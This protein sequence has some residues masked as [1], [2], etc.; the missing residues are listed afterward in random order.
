[1]IR[2]IE[3][4][5]WRPENG[6]TVTVESIA[7]TAASLVATP[8]GDR[9][10][11][12]HLADC[13]SEDGSSFSLA[14]RSILEAAIADTI[15]CDGRM[16]VTF[17]MPPKSQSWWHYLSVK[18]GA[19]AAYV[20]ID[21]TTTLQSILCSTGRYQA[22]QRHQPVVQYQSRPAPQKRPIQGLTADCKVVTNAFSADKWW[23][24]LGAGYESQL[25]LIDCY[26][27]PLITDRSTPPTQRA[28]EAYRH[29]SHLID[30]APSLAVTFPE[31]VEPHGW[32]SSLAN[33]ESHA[34]W[35]WLN[36]RDTLNDVL[37]SRSLATKSKPG[38][39]NSY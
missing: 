34:G 1:V 4:P 10:I 18:G 24:H 20:W 6:L 23:I 36:R 17:P 21:E 15:A 16:S 9:P 30:H 32:F 19:F 33:R 7:L 26:T 35:L 14:D 3:R 37:V 2:T 8:P 31:P 29:A 13:F 12:I 5:E 11:E 39:S 28:K 27:D 22:E 38:V 25:S